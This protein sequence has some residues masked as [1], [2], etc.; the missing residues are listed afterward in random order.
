MQSSAKHKS[1]ALVSRFGAWF[2]LKFRIFC[3]QKYKIA[4]I[5]ISQH[6]RMEHKHNGQPRSLI[7]NLL[8]IWPHKPSAHTSG[9]TKVSRPH[10]NLSKR[11]ILGKTQKHSSSLWV[12]VMVPHSHSKFRLCFVTYTRDGIL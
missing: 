4:N 12:Y 10:A 9:H 8:P 6:R 1:I 2:H 3:Y 7:R 11:A 5:L